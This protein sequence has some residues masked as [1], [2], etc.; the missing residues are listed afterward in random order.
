[1]A[2][3]TR[4]VVDDKCYTIASSTLT[5][6]GNMIPGVSYR[7]PP[8]GQAWPVIWAGMA[9]H[10]PRLVIFVAYRHISCYVN[11]LIFC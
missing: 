2:Y 7:S 11:N 1:M 6:L 3:C 10:L 5:R 9:R 4:A 8:N